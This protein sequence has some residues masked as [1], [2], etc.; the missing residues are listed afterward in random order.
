MP[1]SVGNTGKQVRKFLRSRG[2]KPTIA[3]VERIQREVTRTQTE[4][5]RVQ[6]IAKE[7]AR[8]RG[9][10]GTYDSRGQ[11]VHARIRERVQRDLERDQRNR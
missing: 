9:E 6:R 7:Q 3:N 2:V 5:E 10:S 8:A 1:N 11:D 4:N